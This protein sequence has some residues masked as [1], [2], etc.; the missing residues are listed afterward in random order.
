MTFKGSIIYDVHQNMGVSDP[1]P[2]YKIIKQK[3]SLEGRQN[4]RPHLPNM[5]IIYE[6]SLSLIPNPHP[7]KRL[8]QNLKTANKSRNFQARVYHPSQQHEWDMRNL[9]KLFLIFHNF[10]SFIQNSVRNVLPIHKQ[11]HDTFP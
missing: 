7:Q 3:T 1:Q 6:P 9:Y 8:H 2:C 5:N 11:A 4:L 10:S